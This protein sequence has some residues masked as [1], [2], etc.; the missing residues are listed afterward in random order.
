MATPLRF[1]ISDKA[2]LTVL[3]SGG[4]G[5]CFLQLF[6]NAYAKLPKR[7]R[8]RIEA[9]WRADFESP[10]ITLEDNPCLVTD[11]GEGHALSITEDEGHKIRFSG[12]AFDWLVAKHGADVAVSLI[13]HEL[14]HVF[15]WAE[16]RLGVL[17]SKEADAYRH[18]AEGDQAAV[19]V[20]EQMVD[21]RMEKWG[22][23]PNPI[24]AACEEFLRQSGSTE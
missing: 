21:T 5:Q 8:E 2:T 15:S 6:Q 10:T 19:E 3:V 17:S 24:R 12:P 23:D 1:P 14:G 11:D 7:V 22:V 13:V 4:D 18:A 16:K 9:H 20:L